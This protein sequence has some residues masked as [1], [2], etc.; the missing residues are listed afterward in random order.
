MD[1]VV[2]FEIP[3]DDVERAKK[4]YGSIFG[5]KLEDFPMEGGEVYTMATTVEVDEKHMPKASGAINGGI[6][7]RGKE[8][9]SPVIAINVDS[10]DES[11]KKVEE[12]GG[13][14][15]MPKMPV[16]DMG[17]YAYVTDSEGNVI[18]LWENMK[19]M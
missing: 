11:V 3:A 8:V 2:H 5:W 4:F 16:K 15:V 12:A 9:S 13:K 6:M 7:K 19:K 18:G 14:T 17:Y 10:I 1:K